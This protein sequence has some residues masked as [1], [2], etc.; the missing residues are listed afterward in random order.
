[1]VAPLPGVTTLKPG[2]ATVATPGVSVRVVDERPPEHLPYTMVMVGGLPQALGLDDGVGGYAC[3]IDCSDAIG[4]ETVLVFG[5]AIREHVAWLIPK[6]RAIRMQAVNYLVEASF[7]D[8]DDE[9]ALS[10]AE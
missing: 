9:A 10:A 4:R 3:V 5:E 8:N 7:A 2:S 1:M 6:D